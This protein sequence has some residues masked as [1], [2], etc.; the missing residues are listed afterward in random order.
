MKVVFSFHTYEL[1][2]W[3]IQSEEMHFSQLSAKEH[4]LIGKPTSE[5]LTTLYLP[6]SKKPYTSLYILM[7]VYLIIISFIFQST[8]LFS[9][10]NSFF[11]MN[12]I[13]DYMM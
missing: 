1:R 11:C 2:F 12:I 4:L 7:Y 8:Y 6:S 3:Y 9:K 5:I 10:V 13:H